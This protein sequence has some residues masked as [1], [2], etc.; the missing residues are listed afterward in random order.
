MPI[1]TCLFNPWLDILWS[2]YT[3]SNVQCHLCDVI[4]KGSREGVLSQG[5]VLH[6]PDGTPPVRL[7]PGVIHQGCISV[8]AP[9]QAAPAAAATIFILVYGERKGY[10]LGNKASNEGF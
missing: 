2:R 1:S 5:V 6:C 3:C 4:I 9:P 8:T 10:G 7:R